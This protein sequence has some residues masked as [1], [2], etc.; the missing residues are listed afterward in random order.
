MFMGD[1]QHTGTYNYPSIK[2]QPEI[3][4]KVETGGKVISSPV[5]SND[6]VYV[7]SGDST[8]YAIDAQSGDISWTYKTEGAIHSTPLVTQGNVMFLS[9]DGFFYALDQSDGELKW[10]FKTNGEF[11]FQV[12]D[13]YNGSFK[14]DFWDFYLSSAVAND[15][16]VYFGSSDSNIYALDIN[17]GEMAWSYKTNGSIHSSPAISNNV[18]VTGSWDSNI[19]GLNAAT[20]EENWIFSTGKD[21]ETYIWLGV[22]ASPSIDNDVV[23]IGS[24]DAKFYALDLNTGDSL[25]TKDAFDRSWMPSTAAIDSN[26]IYT[27]S[28]DS[29]SFFSMD[30]NT[31]EINYATNT[32]AYTFSSPAIDDEMAYIGSANGRLYGITLKTGDIQW[33]FATTGA[34]TDT[35]NIFDSKGVMDI[36]RYKSLTKGIG[37]MPTLS[38]FME[39]AFI[40]GG[41]ILSSPALSDQVIYFGSSDGYIYAISDK[42]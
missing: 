39:D 1:K 6:I 42:P 11:R 31:G 35:L 21:F 9:Y 25:W 15:D 3:L 4:W 37:D 16:F 32:K 10:K 8:L 33:E 27:G 41:A 20:G 40:Q 28:S 26:A 14:E 17:S 22:Q 7:G 13:Y 34:R 24:R 12:K 2:T 36:E 38:A 30:R 18:L 19:Y 23:Y 5:I 29:F